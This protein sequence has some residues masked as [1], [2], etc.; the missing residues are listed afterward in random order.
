VAVLRVQQVLA[1]SIRIL[2]P[3]L[4]GDCGTRCHLVTVKVGVVRRTDE[5]M[6]F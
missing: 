1:D 2:P 3:R 5:V 4:L 6:E